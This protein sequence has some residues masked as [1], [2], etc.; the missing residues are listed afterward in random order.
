M[1]T[2]FFLIIMTAL[3]FLPLIFLILN[4]Q[5][6]SSFIKKFAK[7]NNLNY[8]ESELLNPRDSRFLKLTKSKFI[9]DVVFGNFKNYP[10]RFYTHTHVLGSQT[11]LL[12][13]FEIVLKDFDFPWIFFQSKSLFLYCGHN[14]RFITE[15][16][17]IK[18]S[19][20]K[21]FNDYFN[22][23]T[24]RGYG[25]EVIQIFNNETLAFLRDISGDYN[26]EFIKNRIYIYSGSVFSDEK[27]VEDIYEVAEKIFKSMKPV[28]K[29][30]KKDFKVLHPYFNK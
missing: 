27:K 20:E 28:L 14:N 19:L 8:R 13:I 11:I 15:K 23:Y 25:I 29:K 21:D 12:G 16:N 4:S 3:I 5:S 10:I 22:L 30:I 26:I 7:N 18:I 9:N 1:E 17:D 2:L 24:Q 6:R